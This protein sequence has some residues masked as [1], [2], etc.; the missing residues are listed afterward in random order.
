MYP[1]QAM[2]IETRAVHAGRKPERGTRD[3]TPA[4]HQSTTFQ[5][6][7]YGSL[8]GGYL[9]SRANNPNRESLEEALASLE[10][11][12][13]ALAVSSGSAA[14]LGLLHALSPCHHVTAGEEVFYGSAILFMS[15]LMVR[16]L[17]LHCSVIA[18]VVAFGVGL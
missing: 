11:G 4:I 8:P 2:R 6:A 12:A 18:T 14:T 15:D 1:K 9:Y 7:D 16:G 3:V 13:A 17:S 5:K 10:E